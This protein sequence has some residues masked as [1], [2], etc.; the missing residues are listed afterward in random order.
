LLQDYFKK[1]ALLCKRKLTD[2]F[3]TKIILGMPRIKKALISLLCILCFQYSFSQVLTLK[4]AVETA[5]QNYGTI[6]AKSY[7]AQASKELVKNARTEYLPNLN[8]AAQ[9]DYGT[10][11]G[12]NGPLYG[13]GGLAAGSSGAP[14]ESQNWNAAFGALYLTNVNWD[15]FA[16]GRAKERIKVAQAIAERDNKDLG[17]EIFQHK[18]RVAGAWLNLQAAHQLTISYQKNVARADT[19]RRIVVARAMGG[20][21]AGVDSSLAN[22]DF[23]NALITYTRARGFEQDQANQLAQLMGVEVRNFVLDSAFVFR[24]PLIAPDSVAISNNPVLLYYKSITAVSEEQSRYLKTLSYPAFTL[25]GV[26]QTRGSG[27]GSLYSDD[28]SDFT[29]NYWNGIKPN[30][31]NYLFGLGVTWNLT[32]P[33]RISKQVKAQDFISK[34]LQEEYTLAEQQVR[35]RLRLSETRLTNSMAIVRQVPVQVKAASDAFVQRSVLYQNGLANL[36]DVSQAL[37]TLVRAE[38]DRDIAYNNIW[39]A[40]LLKAAAAGDFSLF[41]NQL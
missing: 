22:A 36:V 2:T 39:Q 30:R 37:Y 19:I 23:S 29:K 26:L 31:T 16:F 10:I 4:N 3:V 13:F 24:I 27:F 20:L 21:V 41:E 33:I 28:Q 34:G 1:P 5:V 14:L 12:Q 11:N 40:L 38:T 7:Y 9:Q 17:Q 18:I 25:V 35:A 32:Q 15:F 6:H 8:V